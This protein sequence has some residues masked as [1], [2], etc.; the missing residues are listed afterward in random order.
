MTLTRTARRRAHAH[1]RLRHIDWGKPTGLFLHYVSMLAIRLALFAVGVVLFF[2]KPQALSV[3]RN[4]GISHGLS[5]PNLLFLLMVADM[6]SKLFPQAH[7]AVGS[8]KQ[9]RNFHVPTPEGF[10]GGREGLLHRVRQLVPTSG[11]ALSRVHELLENTSREGR[12]LY[13]QSRTAVEETYSGLRDG[14]QQLLRNVDVLRV[15]PFD[16]EDL[17]ADGRMRAQIRADRFRQTVPVLLFWVAFNVAVGLGL[18]YLGLLNEQT[19]L[20]WSTFYFV[21]D[22]ICVV[23]WC[24]LQLILMRNRCCTT[25]QIFNWDAAMYV[26]P[27]LLLRSPFSLLLVCGALVVLVRWELA[28]FRHPERF[29]ERTNASLKCANCKDR[30][31]YLRGSLRELQASWPGDARA[32][33]GK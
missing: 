8:L 21:F 1:K 28:F 14:A 29:D 3:S 5:Y 20:L 11:D 31:C 25:C 24:P 18:S 10:R 16:D 26:T 33:E 4:F 2:A 6:V 23:L 12:R 7:I 13:D 15:L 9:Y 19:I 27:L 32:A 17:T 22:M 30:L